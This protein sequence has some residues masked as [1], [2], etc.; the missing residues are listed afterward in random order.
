[1]DIH[2]KHNA[3]VNTMI[4]ASFTQSYIQSYNTYNQ[5]RCVH[6]LT[7]LRGVR[8]RIQGSPNYSISARRQLGE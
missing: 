4:S 6:R 7:E 1:M 5:L 8:G 3:F 2:H